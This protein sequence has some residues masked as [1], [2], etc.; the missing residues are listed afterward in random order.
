MLFCAPGFEAA[1]AT[2]YKRAD[3][4]NNNASHPCLCLVRKTR[5]NTQSHLLFRIPTKDGV[6]KRWRAQRIVQMATW[7]TTKPSGSTARTR[8]SI[9]HAPALGHVRDDRI[10][11]LLRALRPLR[12]RERGG[13]V[14]AM[15]LSLPL[16]RRLPVVGRPRPRP[17]RLAVEALRGCSAPFAARQPRG[18]DEAAEE[19]RS[20]LDRLG[21]PG[22][23]ANQ[24]GCCCLSKALGSR[25]WR[26][27]RGFGCFRQGR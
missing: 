26:K 17:R 2:Y 3:E 20:R 15:I 22:R 13:A 19:S 10:G 8:P 25:W 14:T 11:R 5:P 7:S 21:T 16:Q 1:R 23:P 12:G 18:H 4:K 9:R 24:G 6:E 27:I